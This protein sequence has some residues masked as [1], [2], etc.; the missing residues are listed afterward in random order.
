MIEQQFFNPGQADFNRIESPVERISQVVDSLP[1]VVEP[2]SQIADSPTLEQS[3]DCKG[4]DNRQSD[5]KERLLPPLHSLIIRNHT[6]TSAAIAL[7]TAT[8]IF[9]G[10][11]QF[12][13]PVQTRHSRFGANF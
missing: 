9:G 6:E 3:R 13:A 2:L 5:L 12:D 10:P 7:P 8:Q 4:D 11:A 1:H